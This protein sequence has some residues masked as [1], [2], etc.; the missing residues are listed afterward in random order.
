MQLPT[1]IVLEQF[2][3]AIVTDPIVTTPI[4][5]TTNRMRIGPIYI[6][7]MSIDPIIGRGG[8]S[9]RQCPLI[10]RPGRRETHASIGPDD[11]REATPLTTRPG[12]HDGN[13][14][15]FPHGHQEADSLTFL[16]ALHGAK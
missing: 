4:R 10:L 14:L 8:L 5:I 1:R 7:P 3:G 15:M 9:G 16:S 12:P 11:P 6:D 13:S 2:M